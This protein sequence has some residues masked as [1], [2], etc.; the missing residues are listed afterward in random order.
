MT[1]AI[2][3]DSLGLDAAEGVGVGGGG[4][5]GGKGGGKGGGGAHPTPAARVAVRGSADSPD[6]AWAA[7]AR[8]EYEAWQ[9]PHETPGAVKLEAVVRWLSDHLPEDAIVNNG[10]GT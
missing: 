9:A 1:M 6:I 2:L 8:A 7:A 4:G 5:G 3:T 10:A